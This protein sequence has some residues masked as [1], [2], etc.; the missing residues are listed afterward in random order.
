MRIKALVLVLTSLFFQN[1]AF[2]Q[3]G[4]PSHSSKAKEKMP[5]ASSP[6][7][8]RA[9]EVKKELDGLL[10]A[11]GLNDE[12]VFPLKLKDYYS[13][14][15]IEID[16]TLIQFYYY[17]TSKKNPYDTIRVVYDS[18]TKKILSA[19]ASRVTLLDSPP[20]ISGMELVY[21][22]Y[23]AGS[24][25]TQTYQSVPDADGTTTYKTLYYDSGIFSYAVE[26]LV[27]PL[28]VKRLGPLRLKS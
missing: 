7:L 20:D 9:A 11:P 13:T 18:Q 17:E 15:R 6:G 23:R 27:Q 21:T 25:A 8:Q 28:A 19:T 14:R 26:R 22:A 2:S 4:L 1:L 5:F 3:D 12:R 16:S 10:A 24:I